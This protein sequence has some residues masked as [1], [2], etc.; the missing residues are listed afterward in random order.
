MCVDLKDVSKD[1]ISNHV[2]YLMAAFA[3]L[4]GILRA[5][6]IPVEHLDTV[7]ETGA[8]FAGFAVGSLGQGPHEP[9]LVVRPDL[10]RWVALA[11]DPSVAWTIGDLF[12]DPDPW[13]FCTRSLLK[14]TLQTMYQQGIVPKAGIEAEFFLVRDNG[15]GQIVPAD[16]HDRAPKTCYQQDVLARHLDFLTQAVE[17]L[18]GLGIDVYQIDHEDAWS[19]FEINWRYDEALATADRFAYLK[20]WV[21][22][23]AMK[24]GLIATFM[25]KPFPALTGSGAHVHLSLWDSF[26]NV[27]LFDDHK[28]PYGLSSL[29]YAFIGG[30]LAHA[31]A[32]AAFVAPTVNSYK[33]LNNSSSRSGATWSPTTITLGANNRTHL[34]R[35]PGPGRF[36]FRAMDSAV[37]PYLGLAAIL[38]AGMDGI[39]RK[40]RPPTPSLENMYTVPAFDHPDRQITRLPATLDRALD[41][42]EQDPV[43]SDAFGEDF[44]TLF[45]KYKREEWDAFHNVVS[46]YEVSQ[47]LQ[48]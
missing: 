38:V 45:L 23:L 9:D 27:N 14:R 10:D 2:R 1:L 28:D 24:Q 29:A 7:M 42:L 11:D 6:L 32:L 4:D 30:V 12:L 31:P 46:P 17:G 13:R 48:F 41:S 18:R 22:R 26:Q 33:R 47:Y 21:K 35:I 40:L 15:E 36:E 39:T 25:P 43:F 19:Q 8:G 16:P 37:N 20:F 5:K 3:D 34:I 44:V